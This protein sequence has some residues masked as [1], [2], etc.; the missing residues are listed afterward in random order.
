MERRER[1]NESS[2]GQARATTE[3][4]ALAE[5]ADRIADTAASLKQEVRETAERQK[6]AGAERLEG[7]AEA[8]HGAADQ[9]AGQLP[10]AAGYVHGAASRIESVS[11]ALR[12]RSIEDLLQNAG[13]LARSQPAALFGGAV[14]AGIAL[15]RFL[16]SSESSVRR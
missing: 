9:L 4:A 16:K 7:L 11:A 6:D 15:S 2:P 13:R 3:G 12:D 14:L 1:D 8:V 5:E 10:Q